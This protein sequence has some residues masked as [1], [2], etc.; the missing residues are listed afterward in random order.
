MNWGKSIIA[1]FVL[2]A[3]FIAVL[4]TVCVRQDVSLVGKDYYRDELAYD[5]QL[6]RMRNANELS[7][8]P[9]FSVATDN[10]LEVRFG[11]FADVEKGEVYLFCPADARR[12]QRFE[13]KADSSLT[14][15]FSLSS[16]PHGM[17]KA[18]MLWTMDGR[19]F[20]VEHLINL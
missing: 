17:Y 16:V 14:Q 13:L 3:V 18:R 1:A 12:D 10:A 19:E 9:S 11:R 15:R 6:A 5:E 20:F 7:V 4:V 8:Q 2:F